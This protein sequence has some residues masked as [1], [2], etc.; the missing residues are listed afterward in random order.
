M[1]ETQHQ[2][3]LPI[4]DFFNLSSPINIEKLEG[5]ANDNYV[6]KTARGNFL[7]KNIL[8]KQ[9]MHNMLSEITY[10]EYLSKHSMPVPSYLVSPNGS[11]IFN[12]AELTVMVQNVVPGSN[13]E[14]TVNNTAQIGKVLGKLHQVPFSQL[15]Q[16]SGWFSPEYIK[17]SFVKLNKEFRG[18]PSAKKIISLYDSCKEF[19]SN[20]LPDLPTSIIHSDVKSDNVIFHDDQLAAVVDWADVIIAPALLDFAIAVGYWCF[21]DGKIIRESYEALYKNYTRERPLTELE[22]NHMAE[23]M[24]YVGVVEAVTRFLLW[25]DEKDYDAI[26]SLRFGELE[27]SDFFR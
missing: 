19:E 20:I 8:E 13:P 6:C 1:N 5:H 15:P 26:R 2:K 14:I 22:V 3:L 7:I 17:E 18:N 11:F 27:A 21:K 16:R 23:C 9:T 10:V 24:K 25:H 4:I 12:N